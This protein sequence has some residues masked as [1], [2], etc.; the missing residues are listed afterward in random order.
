L[1][2]YRLDDRGIEVTFPAGARDFLFCTA[3]RPALKTIQPPIQWI[4][5]VEREA[6][7]SPTSSVEVI[8]TWIYTSAPSHVFMA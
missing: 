6:D 7:H 3:P 8:N 4:R 5:G 1:T 2:G